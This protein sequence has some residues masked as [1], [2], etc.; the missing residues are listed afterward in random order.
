MRIIQSF[1]KLNIEANQY[2]GNKL[3]GGEL[4]L[5][6]YSFL[7][8]YLT[9]K[10]WYGHVTMY[11]NQHA[12]DTIIKH[13]PYD[14]VVILENE[15]NNIKFWS[16]YK[17]QVMNQMKENFIHVDSDVFIFKDI[18]RPFLD[19]YF[20]GIVQDKIPAE[21]NFTR[22]FI[23][24]N[25]DK[26]PKNFDRRCYSCG[27]VGMTMPVLEKY[28]AMNEYLFDGIRH[29]RFKGQKEYESLY[30]GIVEELGFY[31]TCFENKFKIH[32]ILCW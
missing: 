31:I 28:R 30:F 11:C 10:K 3:N 16:H 13:I 9:L 29:E 19:G 27:V 17:V 22:G 14:D 2:V 12:Y 20:D 4:Y 7:L 26:L 8:S 18:L 6:L 15:Y 23:D 32:E 21:V 24:H 25:I 5:N 1:A